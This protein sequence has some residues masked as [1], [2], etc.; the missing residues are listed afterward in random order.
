NPRN[1][2]CAGSAAKR[3][4]QSSDTV[5]ASVGTGSAK[6]CRPCRRL[7]VCRCG[8]Q[9]IKDRQ[10]RCLTR[11]IERAGDWVPEVRT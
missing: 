2:K 7:A 9:A 1:H 11:Y 3:G 4:C 8:T 6:L 10:A 5:N